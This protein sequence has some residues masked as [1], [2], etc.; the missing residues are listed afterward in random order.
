MH[1]ERRTRSTLDAYFQE[2]KRRTQDDNTSSPIAPQ[3]QNKNEASPSTPHTTA[4]I[5][6]RVH[7]FDINSLSYDL[8]QKKIIAD[9]HPDDQ[10][11]VRRAYIQR[12]VIQPRDHDF[13]QRFIGG[14]MRCF[15]HDL[16]DIGVLDGDGHDAFVTKCFKG[17]YRPRAFSK[18]VGTINSVHKKRIEK[19][20]AL[21]NPQA[22]IQNVLS[23]LTLI[24]VSKKNV[25]CDWLF[26][27]LSTMLNVVGGSCKRQEIFNES[28]TQ[29]VAKA[30]EG[31]EIESGKGLNQQLGLGRQ[32][33]TRLRSN[34]KLLLNVIV[35]HPA[36]CEVLDMIFENPSKSDDRAKVDRVGVA[37][38]LLNFIFMLQE[39]NHRFGEVSMELL[40]CMRCLNPVNSF[41][42]FDKSK[43]L[44]LAEFY[45]NEFSSSELLCLE[46]ELDNFIHDMQRD[47]IFE[48]FEDIGELSKKLVETMKHETYCRIYLL[49]KMVLILHVATATIERALSAMTIVR[50]KFRG[51]LTKLDAIIPDSL[52]PTLCAPFFYLDIKNAMFSIDG[53][54]AHGPDAFT[55]QVFKD[56]WEVVGMDACKVVESFFSSC[57]ILKEIN[58]T[59]ITLVPK[60][61]HLVNV[62]DFRLISRSSVLLKCI[63]K[64]I[65]GRMK[66]VLPDLISPNQGGCKCF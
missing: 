54:K 60:S 41:Y 63:S 65:C 49:I 1:Q 61:S 29:F 50:S 30:F 12:K 46:D 8:G 4:P 52:H 19:Y 45:P 20:N 44:R 51:L 66:I 32:G 36:I 11:T 2:K 6:E 35:L 38:V 26:V 58:A 28:Q 9:Y 40:L 21:I 42:Y 48:D 57:K 24:A 43:L 17:W 27:L 22:S 18:H 15:N 39:L 62:T 56:S 53:E 13:Q 16:Y 47:E 59:I 33:D 64:L 31:G 7:Q 14:G 23:P 55:S 10:D 34:Y 37:L 5:R 3:N 25:D